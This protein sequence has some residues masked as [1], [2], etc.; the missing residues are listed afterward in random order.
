MSASAY[1]RP[2]AWCQCVPD[3]SAE[4]LQTQADRDAYLTKTNTMCTVISQSTRKHPFHMLLSVAGIFSAGFLYNR[5]GKVE[6]GWV[7]PLGPAR[8]CVST[9][10]FFVLPPP[11]GSLYILS[12]RNLHSLVVTLIYTPSYFLAENRTESPGNP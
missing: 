12:L 11:P 2:L 5:L 10:R 1:H 3:P 7:V 4:A 9:E 8:Y 6:Q